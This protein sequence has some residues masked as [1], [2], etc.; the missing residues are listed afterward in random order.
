MT[1]PQIGEKTAPTILLTRSDVSRLLTIEECIAAVEDAFRQFGEGTLP[2]PGILGT[3]VDGGGFHIKAGVLFIEGRLFYAAKTNANFP[4]NWARHGLPTIQGI[5]VLFDAQCGSPLAI[6]DSA[7]I[8]T[9]RTGAATA[10][11]AKSLARPDSH[12]LTVIG[13]GVQGRVQAKALKAVLPIE[14]VF[15]YDTD[16]ARAKD[17]ATAI[18]EE[19]GVAASSVPDF[20][21]GTRQSDVIVTCTTSSCAFLREEHIRAGTFIAAVGADSEH[22]QELDPVLLVRN[23]VV[24]DVIDQ[25]A[26]IGE[27]HHAIKAELV[28]Q[29]SIRDDLGQV[30][31]GKHPG[32]RSDNEIIIF[33][34]TGMALQDVAAACAVYRRAQTVPHLEQ[35]VLAS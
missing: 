32:R 22:K 27:L 20:S 21:I 17:F 6:M 12:K 15:A 31:A 8:T 29:D 25:A 13:C 16:S 2:A 1:S 10:V 26:S 14:T 7:E 3:H 5:L 35:I 34:S 11:A 30:V 4:D 9:L 19:L 28:K 18:S 23:R 33:D 24:P